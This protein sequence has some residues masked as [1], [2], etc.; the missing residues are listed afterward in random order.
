VG[1]EDER[2][3]GGGSMRKSAKERKGREDERREWEG[4]M[5][6]GR[7]EREVREGI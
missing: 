4:R 7:G 2:E 3:R 5:R 6:E 1:R